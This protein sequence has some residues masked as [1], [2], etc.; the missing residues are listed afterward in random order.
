MEINLKDIIDNLKYLNNEVEYLKAE[1]NR[2]KTLTGSGQATA[3]SKN[4]TFA[5]C[6]TDSLAGVVLATTNI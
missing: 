5:S 6:N 3:R 4:E 1:N 2:L